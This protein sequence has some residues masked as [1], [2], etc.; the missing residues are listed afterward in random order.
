VQLFVV[1]AILPVLAALAI[2]VLRTIPAQSSAVETI[3]APGAVI[4]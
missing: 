3:S 1:L 2:V 4:S